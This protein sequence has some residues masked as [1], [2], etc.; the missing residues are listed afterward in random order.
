[1]A[2]VGDHPAS[3]VRFV[4]ERPLEAEAPWVYRGA[5]FTPLERFALEVHVSAEGE[6]R[7]EQAADVPG[8]LVEK[9]RL[10]FRTLYRQSRDTPGGAPPRR[11][12]RWRGEP[13]KR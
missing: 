13:T 9:A 10:L 6:V 12:V 3:G 4:L 7:V 5:A 2:I 8:E 11:V 1:M